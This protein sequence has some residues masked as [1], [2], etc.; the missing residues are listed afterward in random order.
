M[1]DTNNDDF[2]DSLL[3]S[4]DEAGISNSSVNIDEIDGILGSMSGNKDVS[5]DDDSMNEGNAKTKKSKKKEKKVKEKKTKERKFFN[6]GKKN[7]TKATDNIDLQDEASKI[8]SET[9]STTEDMEGFKFDES[10]LFKELDSLD[11]IEEKTTKKK[12]EKKPK[13]PKKAK[14]NKNVDKDGRVFIKKSKPVVPAERI[15]ISPITY[16]IALTFIAVAVLLVFFGGS[17]YS[18]NSNLKKASNYYVAKEYDK[19]YSILAGMDLKK[20]DEDFYKQVKNIMYVKKHLNDFNT[21]AEI[22][23]YGEGLE[24]L[25]RGIKCYDENI[26]L[27]NELGTAEILNSILNEIDTSLKSY[28]NMSLDEAREILVMENK[29]EAG[30]LITKKAQNVNKGDS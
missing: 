1:T 18:Y 3:Q 10:A 16:P 26:G 23:K 6:K 7:K 19:A 9:G 30:E 21:Y 12:K 13:K 25:I 20:E 28:Y 8:L 14:K 4:V 22:E 15:Y 29:N 24:A 27:S 2:L 5:F 11:S 17:I